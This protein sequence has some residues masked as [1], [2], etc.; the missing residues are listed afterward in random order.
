M[1]D[2]ILRIRSEDARDL[3]T[4]TDEDTILGVA[5]LSPDAELV[6]LRL[7]D[8]IR[9]MHSEAQRGSPGYLAAKVKRL[10]R[11]LEERGA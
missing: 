10:E 6:I 7:A 8:H 9:G 2:R 1:P 5:G 3:C 4:I 11:E